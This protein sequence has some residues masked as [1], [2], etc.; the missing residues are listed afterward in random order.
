MADNGC[1][2]CVIRFVLF[3]V[4]TPNNFYIST[5]WGQNKKPNVVLI[6]V[7]QL[8]ISDL[9]K[10]WEYLGGIQGLSKDAVQFNHAYSQLYP[11]SSRAALLTGRLPVKT[12]ILKGRFLPFTSFP[13]IAASGGLPLSEQTLAEFLK[14]NGYTSKFIGLWDQGLGR[15]GKFLPLNQGFSSWFG[16]VTQHSDACS[17][18]RQ[19]PHET[20][21]NE[22]LSLILYGMFWSLFVFISVWCFS[23]LKMKFISIFIILGVILYVTNNRTMYIAIRSCVLYK[24]SY[25]VAQPYDVENITLRFTDEALGFMKTVAHPFFLMVNHLALSRPLFTSPFFRNTSGQC[26]MFLDSLMELDWSVKSI[27]RMIERM[28]LTNDTIVIFTALSGSINVNG[29]KSCNCSGHVKGDGCHGYSLRGWL[30]RIHG[31]FWCEKYGKISLNSMFSTSIFYD[32]Y[33]HAR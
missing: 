20:Y 7:N 19:K 22:P 4:F 3:L 13:S 14:R 24:D 11:T 21:V 18:L 2:S 10:Y 6:T 1:L 32:V 23:F 30:T 27:S 17:N 33:F 31:A 26:D 15:K 5:V 12:G 29:N 28:G 9:N 25:I 16:V 8:G